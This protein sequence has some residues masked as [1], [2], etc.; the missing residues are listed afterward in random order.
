MSHRRIALGGGYPPTPAVHLLRRQQARVVLLVNDHLSKVV[1]LVLKPHAVV[2]MHLHT[3][4]ISLV[5]PAEAAKDQRLEGHELD[6]HFTGYELNLDLIEHRLV[7]GRRETQ[8][9]CPIM[10]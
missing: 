9:G 7:M 6:L 8:P 2:A 1:H 10:L 5:E 3:M 4:Y